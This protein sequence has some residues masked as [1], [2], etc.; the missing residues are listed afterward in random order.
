MIN[1]TSR[2]KE[3]LNYEKKMEREKKEEDFKSKLISDFALV[4]DLNK[5]V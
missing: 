5:F 4:E 1:T 2:V 3:A